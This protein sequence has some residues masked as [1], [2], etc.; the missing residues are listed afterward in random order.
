M[1]IHVQTKPQ[2]QIIVGW[3]VGWLVGL[4][5]CI[6]PFSHRS[7]ATPDN[8]TT[9]NVVYTAF[10][11]IAYGIM[12]KDVPRAVALS[13]PA[14]YRD[15]L[16]QAFLTT[17]SFWGW[18]LEGICHAVL[19]T[20]IP[21]YAFGFFNFV[22]GGESLSLWDMGTIV[23]LLVM[24][25]ASLRVA[26]EVVDWQWIITALLLAS[27]AVWWLSW[28]ALNWWLSLAPSV[29][30]SLPKLAASGQFWMTYLCATVACFVLSFA[31]E[32]RGLVNQASC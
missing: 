2:S 22:P 18:M 32:V 15:G 25:V 29:F 14:L 28:V 5:P 9:D 11:I 7:P 13:T 16:E 19:V 20:F 6:D 21:I 4:H 8:P 27:F 31:L 12:D 23:F 17:K 1:A 30:G 3:R 24:T 10:P 26:Q